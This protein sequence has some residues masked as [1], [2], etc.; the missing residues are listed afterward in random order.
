VLTGVA[1]G[2]AASAGH[3]PRGERFYVILTHTGPR[4][5]PAAAR[6][7]RDRP[8]PATITDYCATKQDLELDT[9]PGAEAQVAALAD[10]IAYNNH[11]I[12]DGLRA[13]LFA[14]ENL[15]DVPLVGPVFAGVV[16]RHPGLEPARLIHESVRRLIDHM[17]T[18]L[19]EETRRLLR[20]AQP[21]SAAELRRLGHPVVAFSTAMADNDR[22]L[23]AFL[24]ERMYRH[25][26]VNLMT[27]RARR[28]VHDL[29]ELYMNAPDR[30]PAD[31]RTGYDRADTAGKA[32]I[33]ADYIAGMTD[34]FALDEHLRHLGDLGRLS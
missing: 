15:A 28:V 32:R 19:M 20:L 31:W 12:D 18:D 7:H 1:G 23:K 30:L 3:T 14:V 26:K 10:D 9:W 24:F 29:Y 5:G 25:E 11:D 22:A 27:A 21:R 34:R 4:A 8:V 2:L 17:V 6:K 33:V 13:G 16:E